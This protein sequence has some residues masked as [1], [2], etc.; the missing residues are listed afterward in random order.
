MTTPTKQ[1]SI[2]KAY[3]NV[4]GHQYEVSKEVT[5]HVKEYT[6]KCCKKELTTNSNGNLTE[7][8]PMFREINSILER[9]YTSKLIRS[10]GKTYTSSIY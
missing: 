4:F 8:T 1:N 7:L 3:C 6:C 5:S 2:S 10:Q 9:I